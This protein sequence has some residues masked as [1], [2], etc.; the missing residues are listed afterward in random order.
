[1]HAAQRQTC[2]QVFID[3]DANSLTSHQASFYAAISRAC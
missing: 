2:E 1:V 3:A